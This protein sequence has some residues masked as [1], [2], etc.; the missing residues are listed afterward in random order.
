M[1]EQGQFQKPFVLPPQREL[2]QRLRV[3]RNTVAMAYAELERE[4]RIS[5]ETLAHVARQF[6]SSSYLWMCPFPGLVQRWV[7][8][9]RDRV[10]AGAS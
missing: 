3:S 8:R 6:T 2:A 1:D 9:T 5:D 10:L 7:R 4:G